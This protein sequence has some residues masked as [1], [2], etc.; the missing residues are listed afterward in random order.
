MPELCSYLATACI[1]MTITTCFSLLLYLP[2]YLKQSQLWNNKCI[3][4]TAKLCIVMLIA[5]FV[6]F[7]IVYC[8][9]QAIHSNATFECLL[10]AVF[11]ASSSLFLYT[12]I[13]LSLP[14]SLP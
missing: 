9:V 1:V 11:A 5:I 14:V 13:I 6:L 12:H 2:V 10:Q 4:C 8:P 7:D 3:I